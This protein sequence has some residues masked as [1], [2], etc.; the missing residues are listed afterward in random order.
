ML[1]SSF[2]RCALL[3]LL[4]CSV[5]KEA[6]GE[7]QDNTGRAIGEECRCRDRLMKKKIEPTPPAILLLRLKRSQVIMTART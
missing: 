1:R 4:L 7:V 3:L 2:G 6:K 5:N